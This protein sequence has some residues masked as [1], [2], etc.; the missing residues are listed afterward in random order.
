MAVQSNS[1]LV[2]AVLPGLAHRT[3]AGPEHG[4]KDL[5]LWSQ[6]I[7]P[8]GATPPHR[9]DCEEVV[10]VVEG[11]GMM[12][13][14]GGEERFRAGDTVIIPRNELH[15]IFNTG[16]APLRLLAAFGMAPVRAVFPDG[17]PIELPWQR[18]GFGGDRAGA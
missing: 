14:G 17:S 10:V 2:Q 18:A 12:A 6:A 13:I 8:H 16:E 5:E 1:D 7:D 3:L 15:Q 4:L 11:E 9:H